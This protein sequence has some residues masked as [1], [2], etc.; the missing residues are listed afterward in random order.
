MGGRARGGEVGKA[1]DS[2]EKR[3]ATRAQC[4]PPR[5]P[6]KLQGEPVLASL[7][8]KARMPPCW[9]AGV[10]GLTAGEQDPSLYP[11]ILAQPRPGKSFCFFS[12]F[13]IS[14]ERESEHE[15]GRGRERGGQRI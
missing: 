12:S 14:R 13:F 1:G 15:Q 9:P 8:R 4:L 2:R 5:F 7:T 6:P 3:G 10:G 11:S